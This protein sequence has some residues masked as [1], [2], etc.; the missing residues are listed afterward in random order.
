MKSRRMRLTGH[1]AFMEEMGKKYR[2]L[3][4]RPEEKMPLGRPRHRWKDDIK[5]DLTDNRI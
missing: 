1:L 4:G 3:R 2:I 5:M